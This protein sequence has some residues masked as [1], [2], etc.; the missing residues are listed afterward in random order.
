MVQG[1]EV[2]GY[3]SGVVPLSSP[4]LSAALLLLLVIVVDG[5]QQQQ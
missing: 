2:L 5:L 1:I 3:L 4:W